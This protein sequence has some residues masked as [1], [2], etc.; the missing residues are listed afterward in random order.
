MYGDGERAEDP[1][2]IIRAVDLQLYEQLV[3]G[4]SMDQ[5]GIDRGGNDI[6]LGPRKAECQYK[7]KK[8]RGP[9]DSS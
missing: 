1:A 5:S 9:K 8:A 7:C 6:R 4:S 3:S 2:E